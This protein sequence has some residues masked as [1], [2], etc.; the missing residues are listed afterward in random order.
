MKRLDLIK[1]T[2]IF[3]IAILFSLTSCS[4]DSDDSTPDNNETSTSELLVEHFSG[5]P[6]LDGE[7]DAM[8]GAAQKLIGT[9]TVPSLGARQTHLNSDGA[10]IE[11]SL[12]LFDPY[13]GEAYDFTLRAGYT[14]TDIYFLLEWVDNIDS[15]DRQSWYFDTDDKLWK[16]EHKYANDATDKF[17]ED[18][19][20]F[21]FPIG[22][23]DGFDAS[24]CYA[25]C[26]TASSIS[27]A[28]DKHTRH[29]LGVDGQKIDMWH[30][31]RVRGNQR[32]C[33][34]S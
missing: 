16:G 10:G 1:L 27:N 9:T 13:S 12:G 17:Y 23:V 22:T 4:D 5:A 15:K 31:K 2:S 25:T 11:E 30:W 19:F 18:K 26:H 34:K 21:L 14:E 32:E 6:N 29:Y 3:A 8:W 24:T 7:I 20:S 33:K 28:K